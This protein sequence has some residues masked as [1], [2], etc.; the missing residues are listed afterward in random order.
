MTHLSEAT[1]KSVLNVIEQFLPA[2]FDVLGIT[3]EE[4]EFLNGPNPWLRPQMP[5]VVRTMN[6]LIFGTLEVMTLPKLVVPSEYVA[7]VIVACVNPA[8]IMAACVIMATERQTGVGALEL[9][10]RSAQSSAIDPTSADQ[11]FALCC[12][13]CNTERANMARVRLR[14]KLGLVIEKAMQ[15]SL[16]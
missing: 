1:A 9:S 2:D 14:Q 15:G 5:N 13:L 3:Q 10:A 7:A 8:N 16:N 12:I 11:L 6:A 4:F